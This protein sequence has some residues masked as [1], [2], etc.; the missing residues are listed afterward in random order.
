ME[1][2]MGIIEAKA[3]E[4]YSGVGDAM[5]DVA[6]SHLVMEGELVDTSFARMKDDALDK[7]GAKAD[8]LYND[9]GTL[10][11]LMGDRIYDATYDVLKEIGVEARWGSPQWKQVYNALC[12]TLENKGHTA[13]A[14]ACENLKK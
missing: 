4:I 11:D 2:D 1:L 13:M 6:Q 5:Y 7:V 10:Q 8:E 12:S 3:S 14:Q 9:V